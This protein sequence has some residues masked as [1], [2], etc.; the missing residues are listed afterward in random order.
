MRIIESKLKYLKSIQYF[1]D[2]PRSRLLKM[3]YAMAKRVYP[4]GNRVV[5]AGEKVSTIF[6]VV[7]GELQL[8]KTMRTNQKRGGTLGNK[9]RN[10]E[11]TKQ[12][13]G[14]HTG[15]YP[16]AYAAKSIT[17]V[18]LRAQ[19]LSAPI[20]QAHRQI[21]IATIGAGEVIGEWAISAPDARH[22]YD[23][24]SM[25]EQ[26]VLYS[27][28][29][30]HFE[31]WVKS[32]L[33]TRVL[34]QSISSRRE[35]MR[36]RRREIAFGTI[37][38][39]AAEEAADARRVKAG[40]SASSASGGGDD[41]VGG[42]DG[43]VPSGAD[44]EDIATLVGAVGGSAIPPLPLNLLRPESL[45]GDVGKVA[46]EITIENIDR[47][48][49]Y[50]EPLEVR[51][52]KRTRRRFRTESGEGGD[53][54]SSSSSSPTKSGRRA[55]GDDEDSKGGDG[56]ATGPTPPSKA[57]GANA[58]SKKVYQTHHR[59]VSVSNCDA[60]AGSTG[61]DGKLL[62]SSA[63]DDSSLR[64]SSSTRNLPL[65]RQGSTLSSSA[66]AKARGKG[67][68]GASDGSLRAKASTTA[69]R[70]KISS[71]MFDLNN[72]SAQSIAPAQGRGVK[73]WSRHDISKLQERM[74]FVRSGIGATVDL[75]HIRWDVVGQLRQK[76]LRRARDIVNTHENFERERERGRS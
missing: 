64:H 11:K 33:K 39:E 59:V 37:C 38:P 4:F 58:Q 17:P 24:I 61:G 28:D 2:W 40:H 55:K 62:H 18:A 32:S 44:A 10:T 21:M 3:G 47:V 74:Q 71:I 20:N 49:G 29:R 60:T 76:E 16:S 69:L 36:A 15:A 23:V 53:S 48:I 68:L 5:K 45:E 22:T 13:V 63:K 52:K 46:E 19:G 9:N 54:S 43:L 8:I 35:H 66:P 56:L 26:A 67:A 70:G 27:L 65:V 14:L 34:M 1:G 12:E 51:R 6:F 73:S 42:G 30:E 75:A 57:T 7:S 31:Y 25:S 50:V 72:M 41:G